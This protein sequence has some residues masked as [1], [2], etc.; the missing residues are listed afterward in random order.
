MEHLELEYESVAQSEG[1]AGDDNPTWKPTFSSRRLKSSLHISRSFLVFAVV[2]AIG[3][4]TILGA[5]RRGDG[6]DEQQENHSTTAFASKAVIESRHG[7]I[8]FDFFDPSSPHDVTC[9]DY[10]ASHGSG[11]ISDRLGNGEALSAGALLCSA[12]GRYLFGFDDTGS[13]IWRDCRDDVEKKIL[14]YHRCDKGCYF[15]LAEN[16]SFLLMDE[17]STAKG[18][19]RYEKHCAVDISPSE[20]CLEDPRYDCPY[21]HLHSSGKLVLHYVDGKGEA[22]QKNSEKIYSFDSGDVHTRD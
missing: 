17:E 3:A 2:S 16:A 6:D 15:M 8:P 5:T 19:V 7:A 11:C 13:L 10:V 1:A 22:K 21:L 12:G 9:A 4:L 20:A 14:V 18:T